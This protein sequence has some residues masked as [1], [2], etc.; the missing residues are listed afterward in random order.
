MS[1]ITE[2]KRFLYLGY[3]TSLRVREP[4]SLGSE[5]MLIHKKALLKSD[6]GLQNIITLDCWQLVEVLV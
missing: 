5:H 3:I 1:F 6:R 4:G 2:T